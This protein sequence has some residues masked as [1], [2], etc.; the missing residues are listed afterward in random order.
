MT[1]AR[2]GAQRPWHDGG[3]GYDTVIRNGTVV[4][5]SGLGSFRADVGIVGD[6]ITFVGRI[7]ERGAKD[8]DA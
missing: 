3:V 5:G 8:I 1:T 4:D 7:R 6:R 2:H